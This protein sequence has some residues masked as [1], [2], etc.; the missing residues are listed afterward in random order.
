MEYNSGGQRNE[1]S[2]GSFARNDEVKYARFK[3]VKSV[4]HFV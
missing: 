1:V 2:L 3:C 4:G